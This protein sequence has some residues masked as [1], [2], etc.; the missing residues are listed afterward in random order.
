MASTEA[1]IRKVV[2]DR[3]D[4]LEAVTG[5]NYPLMWSDH[6]L[7]EPQLWELRN[8]LTDVLEKLDPENKFKP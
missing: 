1:I 6:N 3:I 4:H 7:S 8:M 2:K 5:K